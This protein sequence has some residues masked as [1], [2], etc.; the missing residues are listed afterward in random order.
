MEVLKKFVGVGGVMV[1]VPKDWTHPDL[2]NVEVA[3]NGV[4]RLKPL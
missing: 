2:G 1:G 3:P 4:Q